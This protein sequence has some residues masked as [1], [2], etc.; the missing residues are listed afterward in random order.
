MHCWSYIKLKIRTVVR[1]GT[2]IP[3]LEFLPFIL[4][5]FDFILI[6]IAFHNLQEE[7]HFSRAGKDG[8]NSVHEKR[9]S[10]P[11]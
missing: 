3:K 1:Y 8:C 2:M 4:F 9:K 10:K 7:I 6:F 11:K 5:L